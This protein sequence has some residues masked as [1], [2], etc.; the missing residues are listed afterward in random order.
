MT[1]KNH[2]TKRLLKITKLFL[3]YLLTGFLCGIL[4]TL[5]SKTISLV[6]GVRSQNN[7]IIF[8][9]PI[10][11][12]LIVF[13]YKKLKVYTVG[14]NQVIEN[15]TNDENLSPLITPSIFMGSVFSHL[16]G[17]SVGR[18]GAALQLG[19]GLAS[20]LSR[21]FS[22]DNT[23]K[24][25]LTYCGMAGVFSAVFG[26][27][28]AA[29]IFALQIT[30]VWKIRLNAVLPTLI[31]SFTAYF[32]AINIGAHPERFALNKIPNLTVLTLFKVIFISLLSALLAMFFCYSLRWTEKLFEKLFK[33]PYIR[34][35]SGGIITVFLTVLLKTTDYNG[36]GVNVIEN[37]F[38][39][40]SFENEAFF[41]KLIFTCIAVGSGYKGGEIVPTLFI[42]A[43]F[44]SLIA[45]LIGL[46]VALGGAVGMAAL[47][48]GVTNCHIAAIVLCLELFSGN[49][50]FYIIIAVFVAL[51]FSGNISLY[52]AQKP[53][54]LIK[55]SI[56]SKK[57]V[58]NS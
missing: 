10:A 28:F 23:Q 55:L 56:T 15:C 32:T 41:L 44:G 26:T 9:L 53:Y 48:S 57:Y 19:G 16:C 30:Y 17:A 11:G 43:T 13:L 36:A 39:N 22:L 31:S 6:T 2:F 27:P 38:E 29:F 47:F 5:F 54:K 40:V 18:E 4:G 42:G 21:T 46:P 37:I 35:V 1:V 8:L 7:W 25:I 14:T 24:Q 12:L 51:L 34:I 49:G 20:F 33:N 58:K 52:S 3:I 50:I 45:S